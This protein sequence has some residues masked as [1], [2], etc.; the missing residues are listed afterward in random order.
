MGS[1]GPNAIGSWWQ[2]DPTLLGSAA[3]T[4]QPFLTYKHKRQ[5]P[6][7]VLQCRLQCQYSMST[8]SSIVQ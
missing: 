6:P 1:T 4:Q 7:Q 8:M 2:Q 5:R 3:T